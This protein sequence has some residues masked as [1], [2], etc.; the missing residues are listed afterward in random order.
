MARS[1]LDEQHSKAHRD[2]EALRGG[3]GGPSYQGPPAAT[4]ADCALLEAA[5]KALKGL[6]P[7]PAPNGI[8]YCADDP[9]AAAARIREAAM[10]QSCRF[11]GHIFR[12]GT[13]PGCDCPENKRKA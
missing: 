8:G 4:S 9:R 13:E 2:R 11:C 12:M 7:R 10:M 3:Y 1:E 5:R 6:E